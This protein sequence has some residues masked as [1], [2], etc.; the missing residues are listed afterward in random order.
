M[1]LN[2]DP[3]FI[4]VET[5]RSFYVDQNWFKVFVDGALSICEHFDEGDDVRE[6]LK[7]SLHKYIS[8][9][10]QSG[11]GKG[12]VPQIPKWGL[13]IRSE[14][15]TKYPDMRVAA[16]FAEDKKQN[17]Q[18][19]VLRHE[20]IDTD[21]MLMLFDREPGDFSDL[22]ITIS[23]PEH[24]LTSILGDDDGLNDA[25]QLTIELKP[26]FTDFQSSLEKARYNS[27]RQTL[28]LDVASTGQF[29]DKDC[30]AV[31]PDGIAASAV[32]AASLDQQKYGRA[33]IVAAQLINSVP[34]LNLVKPS[35][36]KTRANFSELKTSKRRVLTEQNTISRVPLLQAPA[37]VASQLSTYPAPLNPMIR[38]IAKT[39]LL[40]LQ[41]DIVVRNFFVFPKESIPWL[42][43]DP[44]NP[45]L[46]KG[47]DL[48]YS[49]P[50]NTTYSTP[51]PQSQLSTSIYN[52]RYT[53]STD[54]NATPY[55]VALV[56]LYPQ[57]LGF[58]TDLHIETK[59]LATT[60]SDLSKLTIQLTV[61]SSSAGTTPTTLLAPLPQN[62]T[63]PLLAP[64]A[65]GEWPLQPGS[66][67][68]KASGVILPKVRTVG[69]G[70]R[71]WRAFTSYSQSANNRPATFN[72]TVRPNSKRSSDYP[73]VPAWDINKCRDINLVVEGVQVNGYEGRQGWNYSGPGTSRVDF[74]V[75]VYE[76]YTN[77]NGS[78]YTFGAYTTVPVYGVD[79]RSA[80]ITIPPG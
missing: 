60:R 4:P 62:D 33:A 1:N 39:D 57:A 74:K 73:I 80:R 53:G 76:E 5:I 61:G 27:T 12:F 35:L 75:D 44:L 11:T 31:R 40:P 22:G 69:V 49:P 36:Q 28:T 68:S 47:P 29:Y 20:K 72:I 34:S 38:A 63:P 7:H 10:L 67:A 8:E 17:S 23:P 2:S 14:F 19:E 26:L 3:N 37:Q 59:S 70:G 46:S 54:P 24:Q 71:R 15:V 64:N 58:K 43:K 42:S 56:S 65:L 45:R 51:P 78:S 50:R 66:S 9:P 6:A 30:R 55:Q 25:K 18:V 48:I 32:K 77:V 41:D 52:I 79:V 21:V 13:L 16:P